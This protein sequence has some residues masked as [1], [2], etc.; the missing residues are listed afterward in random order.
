MKHN[1]WLITHREYLVRVK[2]KSFLIMTLLTP[3]LIAGFYA[4]IIWTTISSMKDKELRVIGVEDYSGLFSE[5]IKGNDFWQYKI[6]TDETPSNSDWFGKLVIPK[7]FNLDSKL[8][9]RFLSQ[10]SLSLQNQNTIEDHLKET[11]RAQKMLRYGINKTRLDSLESKVSISAKKITSDGVETTTSSIVNSAIGFISAILIYFFIFIYGTMVMKGVGEEKQNRIVEVII[12]TV[13]PFELMLGK[14]LGIASVG[15]TQ[16][17]I[18]LLLSAIFFPIVGALVNVGSIASQMPPP[19]AVVNA[20]SMPNPGAGKAAELLAALFELNLPLILFCFVFFFISGY[21]LY[22]SLFAAIGAAVDND[23]DAQQFVLPV[24][25]PLI[26]AL[27]MAQSMVLQNPNGTL[28]Q[29][30]SV[31]PF[32]SPVVMMVRLPFGV[33]NWQLLLSMISMIF[34]IVG[35]IWLASRIY[36]V[37]ILMYGKK[38]TYRELFKWL[39]YKG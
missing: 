6:I 33:E 25:L 7:D 1:I 11:L 19:N 4:A 26:F 23:T 38:V 10:E 24:T 14:V 9:A 8:N 20:Q 36:R 28:A 13:K 5:G 2:K 30:L 18:W 34:G 35:T 29:W 15:F 17:L 12:S 16:L 39:F 27:I 31:I 3:L 22:S 21:L 32:T 37:G